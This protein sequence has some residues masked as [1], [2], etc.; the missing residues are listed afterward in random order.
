LGGEIVIRGGGLFPGEKSEVKRENMETAH[1]GNDGSVKG[2]RLPVEGRKRGRGRKGGR[3]NWRG[4]IGQWGK[5]RKKRGKQEKGGGVTPIP[6]KDLRRQE[7]PGRNAREK[8][9]PFQAKK[10]VLVQGKKGERV[11]DPERT[12]ERGNSSLAKAAVPPRQGGGFCQGK[13][14]GGRNSRFK[15]FKLRGDET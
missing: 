10:A 13:R 9:G 6:K 14:K 12:G 11:R 7:K 5:V 3:V 1:L 8:G 15:V 2:K 4:P